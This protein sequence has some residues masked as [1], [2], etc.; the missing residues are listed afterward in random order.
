MICVLSTRV[1]SHAG[2]SFSPSNNPTHR[3]CCLHFIEKDTEAQC[4]LLRKQRKEPW[5]QSPFCHQV[6]LSSLM[7]ICSFFSISKGLFGPVLQT[8][9]PFHP[10]AT[11]CP[12]L[13]WSSLCSQSL[14]FD[15]FWFVASSRAVLPHQPRQPP[16]I[17]QDGLE[18]SAVTAPNW[19]DFYNRGLFSLMFHVQCG[20]CWQMFCPVFWT[21]RCPLRARH[22]YLQSRKQSKGFLYNLQHLLTWC[23][24]F[25][26][27]WTSSFLPLPYSQIPGFILPGLYIIKAGNIPSR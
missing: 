24:T 10:T 20:S 18:D 2:N 23:L 3:C 22:Q 11:I 17:S 14:G 13:A 21:S 1:T 4:N 6:R 8:P 27:F 9:R 5:R 15:L 19:S 16:L 12:S 7:T 25:L 26:L